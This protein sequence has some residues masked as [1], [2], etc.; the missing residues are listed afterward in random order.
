[1]GIAWVFPG[2]G[3]QKVGMASGVLELPGA[4]ER[5]AAASE[6]LGRDLLAICAGEASGD[7][8]DLNDTRNTQP[9]LFVIES[10]LVDGLKAQGRSAQLVAGHSLGELVALYA[11]G[12]FDAETG[13]RLM[14]VRSEL[15][16]AAG[17]GAMTAVMGFDRAQ[18]E[19]LVAATEGVV[20]ANDNSSA[21]VVLS[22][23]PE[24]VAA[25]SGQLTCKRAIPLA[26]SGAFHS[27]FMAMAAEAFA[28]ELEAVPFADAA[29]PVLSNTDPTPETSGAALK[30]RLRSQMTTGVRWR[31]TMERF[32]AEGITTAVEIGP[33]NVLSGLIKRSCE[34]ITTAQ[35]ASAADLGL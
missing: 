9:A 7:L 11:A 32:S 24:A 1:M 34:G 23:S 5:F 18:L 25:V 3:S 19:E 13:L 15:M 35:I 22:G 26:V 10:L 6:L 2:Q 27:P 4:R 29:I 30:A 28:H 31:E 21:Q 14:N 33:G 20:I 16:A 8:T 12:V 17:G